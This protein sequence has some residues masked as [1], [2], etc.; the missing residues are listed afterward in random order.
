MGGGLKLNGGGSL[1]SCWP[2]LLGAR[3]FVF[4][5]A[6]S[7]VQ[8]GVFL[9]PVGYQAGG[10]EGPQLTTD[11]HTQVPISEKLHHFPDTAQGLSGESVG[12]QAGLPG[13]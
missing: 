9:R 7:H 6:L 3:T 13:V 5:G 1:D 4:P 11:R 8:V 2:P 10:T 12:S